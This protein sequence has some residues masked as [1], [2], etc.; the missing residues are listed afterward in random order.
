MAVDAERLRSVSKDLLGNKYRAEVGAAIH[1]W[2]QDAL[3]ALTV[4]DF[5]GIR[6]ARVQEELKRLEAAGLLVQVD[7]PG[8]QVEYKASPTVYWEFCAALFEELQTVQ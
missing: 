7:S 2:E 8:Q 3:T 4:S 5:T 1:V 6:Y